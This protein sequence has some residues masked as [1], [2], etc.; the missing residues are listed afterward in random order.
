MLQ[1][2]ERSSPEMDNSSVRKKVRTAPTNTSLLPPCKVCQEPAAGFHYGA[3]TCEAC[4][5]SITHWPVQ[6]SMVSDMLS[7]GCDTF[8]QKWTLLHFKDYVNCYA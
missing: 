3:N 8:I 6:Q 2:M 4:K 5:V 7:C 1:K